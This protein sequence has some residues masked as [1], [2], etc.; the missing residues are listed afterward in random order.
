M[1]NIV[2]QRDY[3]TFTIIDQSARSPDGIDSRMG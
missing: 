1:R 3:T 2:Q